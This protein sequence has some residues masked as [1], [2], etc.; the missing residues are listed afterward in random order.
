MLIDCSKSDLNRLLYSKGI[1]LKEVEG[2]AF[3]LNSALLISLL[4]LFVY[5]SIAN[6]SGEQR[7]VRIIDGDTIVL[8]NKQTVRLLGINTPEIGYRGR[9]NDE[10]ALIAKAYLKERLQLQNVYLEQD[11]ESKDK[12]GRTLAHVFLADGTHI[13]VEILRKGLAILSLHPPNLKYTKILVLAQQHA[14]KQQL[15]VCAL[16]AYQAWPASS[17]N[18]SR[19]KKWGRFEATVIGFSIGKKGSKLRLD[20]KTYIWIGSSH[21]QYFPN[22]KSYQGKRIEI[23]GWPRKWGKQFSIRAIHPSQIILKSD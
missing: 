17:L 6:A 22:L 8:G 13:N 4:L 2:K 11:N 16:G 3:P 5:C 9:S 12:Y 1:G 7:V 23:R 18:M 20:D 14:E 10:G 21:R 15:G 19:L